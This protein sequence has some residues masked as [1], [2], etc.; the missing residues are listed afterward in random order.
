[1][2]GTSVMPGKM[3]EMKQVVRTPASWKARMAS[4]RRA[5]GAASS[6]SRRKP[7]SSVLIDQETR[8]LGKVRMRSRSRSTRSDLV[9][10]LTAQSLPRI[11]S[12]SARVRP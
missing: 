3:G 10:M 6:M 1:M 9:A 5:M 4:R 8:A 2:A 12:S 7:S 11:C